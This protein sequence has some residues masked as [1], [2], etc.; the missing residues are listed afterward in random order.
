MDE[1]LFILGAGG[2]AKEAYLL[3]E[4]LGLDGGAARC[5]GLVD[6]DPS[7]PTE[8]FGGR[9][10]P[11]F[12]QSSFAATHRGATLV[13]GIAN[14]RVIQGLCKTFAGWRFATL[15]DP[16]VHVH[17]STTLGE[18]TV[19]AAGTQL[20][21]DVEIGAFNVLN[22]GVIVGHDTRTGTG[23]VLNP[24]AVL[25]GSV[26]L[27][28]GNLVGS[29]ATVLQGLQVGSWATIG[30][31]A[32]VTR[33]VQDGALMKGVPARPDPAAAPSGTSQP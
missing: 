32:L 11:V 1:E 15:V 22:P 3:I 5:A 28:E 17:P 10:L 27:G 24:G 31:A 21:L 26:T 18:G 29:R 25:S 7:G 19:V 13:L 30:A 16:S 6:V 33:D 4:R 9:D 2:F 20:S 8:R 14:P 12:D 23:N